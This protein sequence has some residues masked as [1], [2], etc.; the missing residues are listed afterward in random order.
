[1]KTLIKKFIPSWLLSF[2]HKALAVLANMVYGRPSEKL[3]VIGVTGTNG[4]ST[5][6]NLIASILEE[7]GHKVG[8][9]STVNFKVAGKE[10]LNDKK[11]TM[12]GR[13]ALQKLLRSMVSAGCDY[14]IIETSSEGI[15]QF[16]HWG[17]NYDVAIFTNLTPEHLEAHGS[18]DNYQK[19]KGELF[20][21]LKRDRVKKIKGQKIGKISIVNLD[22]KFASYFLQFPADKK[23]GYGVNFSSDISGVEE[24][25]AEDIS[26]NGVG[27]TFQINGS[28]F[29]LQLLGRFNV[30]NALAAISLGLSQ[31]ISLEKIAAG[32]AKVKGV[33]GRL[34]FIDEGQAFKVLVDYAPE[35]ESMKQ[36]YQT[37]DDL[38]L[39]PGRIIHVLGSAG[40]GRDKSR[41]PVLGELAG[42]RAQV[43]IITN[44][45]PYNEDP[46][47]II[48]Q[49][50]EGVVSTGK[51]LNEELFKILN[52]QEAIAKA[53]SIANSG[54]LVLI[55]G[56]GSEQAICLKNGQK[57]KWD[58]RQV[59][60]DELDKLKNKQNS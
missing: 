11:M 33:P 16:R 14:A 44:E 49:V 40:G 39:A 31:K 12:L 19:A 7:V 52:R 21:K 34:E 60:R 45:D 27:S 9:T 35:P 8:L 37:I 47:A 41:R 28:S 57:V 13:L 59:V 42:Q 15:K 48:D 24:V 18:F 1:M 6:V 56:K 51:S 46:Q 23:Y 25:R 38:N 10:W 4:K 20:K 58:D 30:Y 53:F 5:T 55:T 29:D 3:V 22:D 17:I 26:L 50:A 43:V 2:Y 32:L 54:D 36:L